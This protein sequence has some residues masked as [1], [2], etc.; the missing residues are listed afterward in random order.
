LV[1]DENI[2][3]CTPAPPAII[4]AGGRGGKGREVIFMLDLSKD[5][6]E[7]AES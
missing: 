5:V 3:S 1:I 4:S 6:V 7:D 2:Q